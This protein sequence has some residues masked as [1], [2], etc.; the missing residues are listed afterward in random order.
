MAG[1]GRRSAIIA[2]MFHIA[3]PS[4]KAATAYG[5]I[6]FGRFSMKK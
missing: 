4:D 6:A 2:V 1:K 5:T 3:A